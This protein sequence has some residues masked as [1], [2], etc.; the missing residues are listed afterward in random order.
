MY[1][2]NQLG[3]SITK[4]D[5]KIYWISKSREKARKKAEMSQVLGVTNLLGVYQNLV[6]FT[7]LSKSC[8]HLGSSP[9]LNVYFQRHIV[10]HRLQRQKT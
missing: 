6:K 10:V 9:G 5:K 8:N 7:T 2:T 4:D 1:N 3:L